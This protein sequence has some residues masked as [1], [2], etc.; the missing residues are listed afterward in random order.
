MIMKAEDTPVRLAVRDDEHPPERKQHAAV[1]PRR[2]GSG[3]GLEIL[4]QEPVAHAFVRKAMRKGRSPV[5]LYHSTMASGPGM[6]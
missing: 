5:P 2:I 1:G 3:D 6:T 4:G